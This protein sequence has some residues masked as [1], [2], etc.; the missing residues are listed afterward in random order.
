[1]QNAPTSYFNAIAQFDE[2]NPQFFAQE[3]SFAKPSFSYQELCIRS[4]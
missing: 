4:Q 1:M 2:I 3:D